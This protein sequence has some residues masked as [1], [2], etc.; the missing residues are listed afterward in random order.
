MRALYERPR[1]SRNRARAPRGAREG[2]ERVAPCAVRRFRLAHPESSG[3]AC[4]A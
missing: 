4:G 2:A 1:A 3:L